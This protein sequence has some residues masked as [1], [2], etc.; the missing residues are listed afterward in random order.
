MSST[1][2]A[3]GDLTVSQRGSGNV[4]D[5]DTKDGKG[6]ADYEGLTAYDAAVI[7]QYAKT[8]EDLGT[9][10]K[11][12]DFDGYVVNGKD[13]NVTDAN[14]V[15]GYVR[16]PKLTKSNVLR[17]STSSAKFT[18]LPVISL[19][20]DT[21]KDSMT[22][23]A[24]VDQLIKD[25][26][27]VL[28]Q[29]IST[30]KKTPMNYVNTGIG[31]INFYSPD[32]G[33]Q[34]YLTEDDGWKVFIKAIEPLLACNGT[35]VYIQDG[36]YKGFIDEEKSTGDAYTQLAEVK[37][38]VVNGT[39]TATLTS[40]DIEAIVK[41]VEAGLPG[42]KITADAVKAAYANVKA[43][44]SSK[45]DV[46]A[47]DITFTKADGTEVKMTAD[48]VVNT[49]CDK[50]LY[51][52]STKTIKDLTDAFGTAVTVKKSSGKAFEFTAELAEIA[53]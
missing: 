47:L 7:Y 32:L 42:D 8:G 19:P 41:A 25:N 2:F 3:A 40:D 20:E 6:V 18:N 49:I 29:Q 22:I 23:Q 48:E 45:G 17:F 33:K 13:V 30:D 10:A 36:E 27:S 24:F 12:G 1:A 21:Y 43:I 4:T 38:L 9:V 53:K 51:N 5:A 16:D 15:L 28:D 14:T 52:Y 46:N 35:T 39:H 37:K 11:D 44:M 26:K 34:V 31:K 50:A